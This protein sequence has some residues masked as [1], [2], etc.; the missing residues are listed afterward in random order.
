MRLS[1]TLLIAAL[2][3]LVSCA[4][5]PSQL[6]LFI[7]TDAPLPPAFGAAAGPNQPAPLFDR[8]RIE[9]YRAGETSPC[10]GCTHEFS[11]DQKLIAERRASIGVPGPIPPGTVARVRLF[12]SLFRIGTEPRPDASIDTWIALPPA[13]APGAAEYTAWLPAERVGVPSGS[14]ATPMDPSPGAP[15]PDRDRNWPSATR[16]PCAGSPRAGE[17]CVPGGAFWM[18]NAR[19]SGAIPTTTITVLGRDD[20]AERLVVLSPFFIDQHE[21]TALALSTW[22]GNNPSERTGVAY[23]AGP[24]THKTVAYYCTVPESQ[25]GDPDGAHGSLPANCIEQPTARRYCQSQGKDLPGEAQFEYVASGLSARRFPWG[26]D[27]PAC[28][29]AVFALTG[30][31]DI[32]DYGDS[33]CRAIGDEGGVRVAGSGRRDVIL[34]GGGAVADL[35]GNLSEW[36]RDGYQPYGGPCWPAGVLRDPGCLSDDPDAKSIRGGAFTLP[37]ALLEAGVRARPR[38]FLPGLKASPVVGF[39]CV[40]SAK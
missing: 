31:D 3:A 9:V 22:L 16:I 8:A 26:D 27:Q 21:V 1:R 5:A 13:A 29:D 12:S 34:L 18:G 40:R 28:G 32:A 39:R 14:A 10:S 23:W 15:P 25:A 7:D 38:T 20:P 37:S 4:R 2:P 19:T 6:L 36:V 30:I 33:S 24:M 17:A 35:A 11:L